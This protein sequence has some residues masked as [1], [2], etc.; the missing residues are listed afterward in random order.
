MS[1][2]REALD[3]ILVI[4]NQS[5]NYSRR[6]QTIH[7]VA[8]KG[9]GLTANQ[10][11]ARHMRIFERIGDEPGKQRWLEREAK[12]QAKLAAGEWEQAA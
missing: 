12:R 5:R 11:E 6:T 1:D 3:R 4:C 8:M 2:L 9:L 7:E 10:R